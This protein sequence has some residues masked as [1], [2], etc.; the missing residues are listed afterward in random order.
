MKNK[1][2][3]EKL[4]VNLEE[5]SSAFVDCRGFPI[6]IRKERC[7]KR[8]EITSQNYIS[9]RGKGLSCALRRDAKKKR[10]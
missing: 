3:I 10:I 6:C 5:I 8:F 9:N 7:Y 4:E 1:A 2:L